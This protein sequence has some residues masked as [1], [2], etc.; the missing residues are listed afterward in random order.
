MKK[1]GIYVITLLL[2]SVITISGTYAF[3]TV[4][5][6]RN[7]ALDSGTHQLLVKYTGD[8]AI[9][10]TVDLVKNKEEGFRRVLTIGLDENSLD[11]VANIFIKVDEITEGFQNDA[12]KWEIYE[13]I[14]NEEKYMKSGTFLNITSNSTNYI[15]EN[16]ALDTNVRTFVVYIWLNGDEA[17]NEVLGAVLQGYIGAETATISGEL[18]DKK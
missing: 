17:G 18:S 9:S 12:F 14:N 10:G 6:E 4:V 1:I 13:L 2:V 16:L 15:A 8:A 5:T 7:N 3:F 11:A